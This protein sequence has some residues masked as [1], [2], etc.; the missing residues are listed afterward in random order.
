MSQKTELT[1]I[2][3]CLNPNTGA[4][5]DIFYAGCGTRLKEYL[6]A[7]KQAEQVLSVM[8]K[9]ENEYRIITK[10]MPFRQNKCI[11]QL[12]LFTEQF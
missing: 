3:Q 7:R 4:W 5:S 12:R 8:N 11:K 2:V 6:L 10:R 1:F 9:Y